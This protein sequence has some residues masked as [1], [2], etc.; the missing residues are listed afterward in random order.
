[1]PKTTLKEKKGPILMTLEWE[2]N[3]SLSA[4]IHPTAIES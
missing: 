1:M 2:L 4:D 3:V